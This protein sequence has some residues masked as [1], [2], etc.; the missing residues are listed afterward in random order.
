R[1]SRQDPQRVQ[2]SKYGWPRVTRQA[3][4]GLQRTVHQ[5]RVQNIGV[6]LDARGQPQFCK[7]LVLAVDALPE[8]LDIEPGPRGPRTPNGAS[9]AMHDRLAVN[10]KGDL[11]L[12][13]L[14]QRDADWH[15]RGDDDRLRPDG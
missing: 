7:Q 14:R 5:G 12:I 4:G 9:V 3:D 10:L 1:A 15:A 2:C 13:A 8:L 6:G 11:V